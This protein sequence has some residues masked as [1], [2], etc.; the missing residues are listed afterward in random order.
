MEGRE[1]EAYSAFLK[2]WIGRRRETG[3]KRK[4]GKGDEREGSCLP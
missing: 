2:D 4:R 3:R 1:G